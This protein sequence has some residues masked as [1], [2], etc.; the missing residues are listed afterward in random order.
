MDND[1][2]AFSII[3]QN[4]YRSSYYQIAFF[5]A[6]N[7]DSYPEWK[8]GKEIVIFGQYGVVVA[9]A[10][11]TDI[12]ISVLIGKFIPNH[13]LCVSGEIFIKNEGVIV[14]NV[15]SSSTNVVMIPSGHYSITVMTDEVGVNTSKV[16]FI[17][18]KIDSQRVGKIRRFFKRN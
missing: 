1:P 11:D 13:K 15:A 16:W 2:Q 7:P 10:N 9:V 18:N 12:E 3:S 8:T 6:E 4:K 17:L 14:G 5:D